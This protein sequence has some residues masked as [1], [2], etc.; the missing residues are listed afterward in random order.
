V[1]EQKHLDVNTQFVLEMIPDTALQLDSGL[2]D[3][4][5]ILINACNRLPVRQREAI[6]L[7][8]FEQLPYKEIAR[9]MGMGK[10][11]SARILVYRA[12]HSLKGLLGGIRDEL[13]LL[14]GLLMLDYT[15]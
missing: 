5:Q 15:I 2:Q 7:Y 6:A 9:V 13:M 3:R 10:V 4:L 12:L 14:L 1:E 11:A 8:F